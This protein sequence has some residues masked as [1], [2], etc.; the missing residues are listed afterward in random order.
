MRNKENAENE[1]ISE[2]AK[3]VISKTMAKK[4]RY[5]DQ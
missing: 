2:G 1:A 4:A 5:S 3:S